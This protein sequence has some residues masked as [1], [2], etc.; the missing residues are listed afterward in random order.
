MLVSPIVGHTIFAI[1]RKCPCGREDIV[2]VK[3]ES[4]LLIIC[5]HILK[6][7]QA[8]KRNSFDFESFIKLAVVIRLVVMVVSSCIIRSGLRVCDIRERFPRY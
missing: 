3:L 2:C 6:R 8:R 5:R 7:I 1:V 4:G